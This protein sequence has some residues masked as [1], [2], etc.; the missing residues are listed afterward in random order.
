MNIYAETNFVQELTF[1]QEQS[2]SCDQILDICEQ[3]KANLIIPA[4]SLVE[5][6]YKLHRQKLGRQDIQKKFNDEIQQLSRTSGYET[7]IQ[8]I[9][10][11]NKLFARSYDEEKKRFDKYRKRILEV[12]VTIPLNSLVLMEAASYEHIYGFSTQDAIVF[13]S[14]LSHLKPN[15]TIQSCFLN[16]NSKD[17]DNPDIKTEL[18]RFNC[19]L[20]PRFDD[21][22]K[23][24]SNRLGS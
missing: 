9:E 19:T 22:Y 21:G 11:L 12:A 10:D 4:F 6:V 8:S 18:G 5:P 15:I 24:I 23:F 20:I 7:R 14:V 2:Q 3:K 1:L 17:F 13:A 16:R